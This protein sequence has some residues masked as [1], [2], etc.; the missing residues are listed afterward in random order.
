MGNPQARWL[1]YIMENPTKMDD[2]LGV[3]PFQ[4]SSIYTLW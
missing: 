1:V 2:D 4:E 3:P